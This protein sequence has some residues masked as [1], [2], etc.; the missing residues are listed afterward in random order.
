M[1]SKRIGFTLVELLIVVMIIAILAGMA[2]GA[3]QIA[4]D[5]AAK[6]R[7][8]VTIQKLHRFV[9]EKYASYQY[10]YVPVSTTGT[11]KERALERLKELRLLQRREM[12]DCWSEVPSDTSDAT[13]A[14]IRFVQARPSNVSDA[15]NP[16][17]SAELLYLLVMSMPGADVAFASSEIGDTDGN[18]LKEFLDGWGQP[19]YF[20][21]WPGQYYNGNNGVISQ[22]QTMEAKDG[23]YLQHDPFDP[24]RVDGNA[25]AVFPLIFSSGPDGMKGIIMGGGATVPY[26]GDA[27][28]PGESD[29]NGHNT[30][31]ETS[32]IYDNITNHNLD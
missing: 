26:E 16:H 23:R 29:G 7:T 25:Y 27:G 13:A 19:I 6:A 10:R 2:L 20:I 32:F 28:S 9:M 8:R 3:L 30:T 12:P 24:M 21:R 17:A 4:Q 18:G 22:L 31:T 11:S 15:Q 14:Q 5:S 1:N